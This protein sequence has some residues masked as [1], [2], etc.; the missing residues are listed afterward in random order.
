MATAAGKGFQRPRITLIVARIHR[1][2]AGDGTGR[3]RMMAVMIVIVAVPP[4]PGGAT[5]P[6]TAAE[7]ADG[8]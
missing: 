1:A 5:A 2:I 6:P 3:R 4:P 8:E 7:P